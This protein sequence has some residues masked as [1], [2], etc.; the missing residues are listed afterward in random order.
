M[1]CRS[2]I[3]LA[4]AKS[5]HMAVISRWDSKKLVN[6]AEQ[7]KHQCLTLQAIHHPKAFLPEYNSIDFALLQYFARQI[8][9]KKYLTLV[10]RSK[11]YAL[12]NIGLKD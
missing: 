7:E 2:Y 12:N 9:N 8:K 1:S 10:N 4:V 11:K 6:R 5:Q 3:K